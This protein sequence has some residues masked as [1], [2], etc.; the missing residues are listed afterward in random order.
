MYDTTKPVAK[1]R[2][3]SIPGTCQL[4]ARSNPLAGKYDRNCD[5]K[6]KIL[7]AVVLFKLNIVQPPI[8][9]AARDTP[10]YRAKH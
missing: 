10:G 7:A 6:R 5:N 8:V 9:A 4:E 2:R 1:N 3:L